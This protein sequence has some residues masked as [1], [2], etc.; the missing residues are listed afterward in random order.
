TGPMLR[1]KPGDTLVFAAAPDP[2]PPPSPTEAPEP[3][4]AS[5]RRRRAAK[6]GAVREELRKRL[7]DRRRPLREPDPPPRY[8]EVFVEGQQWL[9]S[10]AGEPLPE[11][12]GD[13]IVDDAL[14]ASRAADADTEVP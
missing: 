12:S 3:P 13:L 11:G 4:S 9:D 8:D 14:W 7:A 2:Q 1:A 6:L 5:A 10:L